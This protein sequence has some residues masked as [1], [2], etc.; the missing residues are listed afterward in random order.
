MANK[1]NNFQKLLY[2]RV[3]VTVIANH[4]YELKKI[5]VDLVEKRKPRNE[6]SYD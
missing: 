4:N 2:I 6:T 1:V 5:K 3:L